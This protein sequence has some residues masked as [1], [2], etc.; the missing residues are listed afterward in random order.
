MDNST[1]ASYSG[2]LETLLEDFVL[3]LRHTFGDLLEYVGTT[4][5]PKGPLNRIRDIDI[6]IVFSELNE[7]FINYVWKIINKLHT[8]YNILLDTRIYSHEQLSDIPPINR[9]LL[10]IFLNDQLGENPFGDVPVPL[11]TLKKQCLRRIKEQES[12]IVGIMP[13][14]AGNPDQLRAVA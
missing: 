14:V 2:S 13:H 11:Q 8:K 5:D 10:R 3:H 6:I 4:T 7:S 9:Y 12:K 1:Y